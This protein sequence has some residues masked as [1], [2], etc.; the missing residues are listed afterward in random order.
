MLKQAYDSGWDYA[1]EK[2]AEGPVTRALKELKL[3]SYAARKEMADK[4]RAARKATKAG[5]PS[6]NKHHPSSVLLSRRRLTDKGE[7]QT[8]ELSVR[9]KHSG[10]GIPRR[11]ESVKTTPGA[12]K[13]HARIEGKEHLFEPGPDRFKSGYNPV[14]SMAEE[15]AKKTK[16]KAQSNLGK[17]LLGAGALVGAGAGGTYLYN[18]NKK[19]GQS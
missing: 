7:L 15:T 12:E 11:I 4:L 10:L 3:N 13:G 9:L 18:R 14:Q 6:T 17:G 2:V 5:T 19:K 1:L 8:K 16:Q